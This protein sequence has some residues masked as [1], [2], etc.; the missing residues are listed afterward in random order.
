VGAAPIG[1]AFDVGRSPAAIVVGDFNGDG[2]PDVA[3]ADYEMFGDDA[4]AGR[5]SVFLGFGSGVLRPPLRFPAGKAPN[6]MGAADFDGDGRPDLAV[7]NQESSD[8][9]VM[10]GRSNGTF[11]LA[12]RF[13]AGNGP[14]G[15][16][17]ADF[18][19][20]GKLDLAVA[21]RPDAT[22]VVLPGLGNGRF[23]PARVSPS[24]VFP[25]TFAAA[26]FDGDGILDVVFRPTAGLSQIFFMKGTGDGTFGPATPIAAAADG[27]IAAAADFDRD[28]RQDLATLSAHEV[29]VLP[30]RGDGTFAAGIAT[31]TCQAAVALKVTRLDADSIPDLAVSCTMRDEMQTLRGLGDGRFS[32]VA[33]ARTGAVPVALDVA[34]LDRD[35]DQDVVTADRNG[36]DVTVLLAQSDGSFPSPPRLPS[37]GE[38]PCD[39]TT[40]DLD[41][42]GRADLTVQNYEGREDHGVAAVRLGQGGANFTPATLYETQHYAYN[43]CAGDADGDAVPDLIASLAEMPR[44]LQI[45]KGAGNGT[46]AVPGFFVPSESAPAGA[47][48]VADLDDDGIPDLAFTT[49]SAVEVHLGLG[50]GAFG[51]GI[52]YYA[53]VGPEAILIEDYNADGIPD[54]AVGNGGV[55]VVSPF[56]PGTVV[57]PGAVSIFIGRGDGTYLPAVNYQVING[58]YTL[59]AG[60]F[61][62]DGILDLVADDSR[63]N[64]LVLK[65]RGDGTFVVL[66]P[67]WAKGFH[68]LAADDFDG[69]GVFDVAMLGIS[70]NGVSLL[71]GHGDGSFGPPVLLQGGGQRP[72]AI[73]AADFDHDGRPDLAFVNNDSE[74]VSIL[75]GLPGPD[76]DADGVADGQDTCT[77]TDGDGVGDPGFAAS[78]C[79]AD[80]CPLVTNATQADADRDGIG[81][82]CDICPNVAGADQSDRDGDQVGDACDNCAAIANI[83]QADR[84]HD[85][86]GDVC[87]V[88]PDTKDP[89]QLDSNGDGS[90]DAC[91]PTVYLTLSKGSK[92]ILKAQVRLHDPENDP[93]AGR[94]RLIADPSSPVEMGDALATEDCSLGFEPDGVPGQGIGYSFAML[95][96]PVLFD[97][98]YMLGCSGPVGN[99][100]FYLAFGT[101]DAPQSA[102][103][104]IL[105]LF[106]QPLP[107]NVCVRRTTGAHEQSGFVVNAYDENG[108]QGVSHLP[109]VTLIDVPWSGRPPRE[110][111]ITGLGTGWTARV[112]LSVT[113]AKTRPVGAEA[114][115]QSQG[116]T[117]LQFNTAA[118][119]SSGAPAQARN[120]RFPGGIGPVNGSKK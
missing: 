112:Q 30:G 104:P 100:D 50:G 27:F 18:D 66:P 92:G 97:L 114:V 71:Y 69:D 56:P 42:D 80:N 40:A 10:L 67:I 7:V 65:G 36:R 106:A 28:G 82:A 81:D 2:V 23:G 58:A 73:G 3:V 52:A 85:G 76:A 94:L 22:V 6:V 4:K 116:E 25:D 33:T 54:L 45:L 9:S 31:P 87:D 88:C 79:G 37:G 16:M 34:D 120:S 29:H 68:G 117:S 113:D 21:S 55:T 24:G 110:T 105:E 102:F 14:A 75:I 15:L 60:D 93:L 11:A 47:S 95:G 8:I 51:P 13:A 89:K 59:G 83:G 109:E 64:V 26:D 72:I 32:L 41:G 1:R 103:G 39:L 5:V 53:G 20:D 91:Q 84:D 43:I 49:E 101:C 12:G 35:G 62:R 44:S 48:A 17:I 98:G 90:G 99:P 108:L 57:I 74:D 111:A 107:L 77:D 119:G 86:V 19:R 63:L 46:F 70:Y 38:C 78:D 118:N 115:F 96:A 61:D